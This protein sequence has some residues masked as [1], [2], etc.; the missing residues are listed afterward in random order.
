MEPTDINGL[1]GKK[2]QYVDANER[3]WPGVITGIQDP[4]I[5]IKLDK[6]PSGLGQGQIIE[7]LTGSDND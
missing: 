6:F 2:V 1:V 3:V 5:V 7:I 4:F